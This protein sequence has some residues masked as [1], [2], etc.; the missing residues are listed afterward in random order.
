MK[1]SESN[2]NIGQQAY[3]KEVESARP[4][5]VQPGKA[6]QTEKKNVIEDKVSLSTDAK[7]MQVALNAIEEA[8]EVR[9]EVVQDIKKEVESGN[10][11]ID[12]DKIADKIA[13]SNIDEI[14]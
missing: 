1:I 11:K 9:E 12:S 14:V 10:Y 8:P 6:E 3:A 4:Q 2:I 13:G 5:E 7:D